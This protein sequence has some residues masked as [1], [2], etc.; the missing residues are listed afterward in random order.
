MNFALSAG[1]VCAL[2]KIH[3]SEIELTHRTNNHEQILNLAPNVGY[4]YRYVAVVKLVVDDDCDV[5]GR[6]T[7]T[8]DVPV[9]IRDFANTVAVRLY[10]ADRRRANLKLK[11]NKLL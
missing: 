7:E 2:H 1:S 3:S 11:K 6:E 9:L 10:V 4:I 5:A 8:S